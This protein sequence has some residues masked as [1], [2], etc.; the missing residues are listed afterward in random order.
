MQ[1]ETLTLIEKNIPFV[2]KPIFYIYGVN[3]DAKGGHGFE[4]LQETEN[5]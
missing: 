3:N 4:M 1:L 5:D 2:I